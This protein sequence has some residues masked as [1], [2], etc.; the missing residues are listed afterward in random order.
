MPAGP[1]AVDFALKAI[2]LPVIGQQCS[3]TVAPTPD[4]STV[5]VTVDP[6]AV[7]YP[8]RLNVNLDE[9]DGIIGVTGITGSTTFETNRTGDQ[10]TLT[11]IDGVPASATRVQ[12]RFKKG[13]D[14]WE[15]TA[16]P[17]MG[18]AITLAVPS[19]ETDHFSDQTIDWV[20]FTA[21]DANEH[22]V[23]AGGGL[24]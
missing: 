23:D 1:T 11:L 19:G 12:V 4:D 21:I 5:I 9:R 15:L 17:T 7:P 3:I 22:V 2:E 20:L 10:A 13:D 24:I 16:D 14:V 8:L 6:P 18:A